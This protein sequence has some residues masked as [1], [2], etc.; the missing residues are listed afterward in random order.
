MMVTTTGA[1]LFRFGDNL[2]ASRLAAS[3]IF[4]ALW[5]ALLVALRAIGRRGWRAFWRQP[6]PFLPHG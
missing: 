6:H 2:L 4:L 5:S 3:P 1:A